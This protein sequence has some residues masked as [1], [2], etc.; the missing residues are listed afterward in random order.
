MYFL[1]FRIS[2]GE[3]APLHY[4]GCRVSSGPFPPPLLIRKIFNYIRL[5]ITNFEELCQEI[6]IIFLP[7]TRIAMMSPK[8]LLQR[9]R[10]KMLLNS[11]CKGMLRDLSIPCSRKGWQQKKVLEFIFY[12]TFTFF[13]VRLSIHSIIGRIHLMFLIFQRTY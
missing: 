8:L 9:T 12:N 2:S 5:S 6:K 13:I 7:I 1:I 11:K 4:A 10:L 3:L